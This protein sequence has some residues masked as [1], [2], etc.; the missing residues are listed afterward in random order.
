MVQVLQQR[1]TGLNNLHVFSLPSS[2][3]GKMFTY[4]ELEKNL[5]K[6]CLENS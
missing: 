6:A 5:I 4:Q 3:F 1:I 2:D